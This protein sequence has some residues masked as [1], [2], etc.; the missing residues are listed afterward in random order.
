MSAASSAWDIPTL[1]VDAE[2]E[3]PNPK[4]TIFNPD[5]VF[6]EEDDK[7][8]L[9]KNKNLLKKNYKDLVI[10]KSSRLLLHAIIVGFSVK[11]KRPTSGISEEYDENTWQELI[12][13]IHKKL[14][15]QEEIKNQLLVWDNQ[16]KKV[17]EE[18]EAEESYKKKNE[19]EDQIICTTMSILGTIPELQPMK[20][21]IPELKDRLTFMVV[22]GQ[23]SGKSGAV[24]DFKNEVSDWDNDWNDVVF[25]NTD[26]YK[27]LL[28]DYAEKQ[29][30]YLWSQYTQPEASLIHQKIFSELQK[31]AN[32][33]KA[34]HVLFDQVYLGHDKLRFSQI[35]GGWARVTLVSTDVD[36]AMKRSFKRGEDE[37]IKEDATVTILRIPRYEEAGGILKGHKGMWMDFGKTLSEFVGGNIQVSI[38][39]NNKKLDEIGSLD[40]KRKPPIKI[41][42]KE[43]FLRLNKK[44]RIDSGAKNEDDMYSYKSYFEAFFYQI[45]IIQHSPY[46][47]VNY[48]FGQQQL[49][50]DR[51]FHSLLYWHDL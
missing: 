31:L 48:C 21:K 29:H 39:D 35:E 13:R 20:L 16:L 45:E 24:E 2:F 42:N 37:K 30:G 6:F 25:V 36:E 46:L 33:R 14:M 43:N 7:E 28:L 1:N 32:E 41:V 27:P 50:I 3:N 38:Y 34:P 19:I 51:I 47:S 4:F 49:P 18:K 17:K 23:A 26:R 5:N 12:T 15:D 10:F 11:F 44:S 22:G 9:Q 8:W 40:M